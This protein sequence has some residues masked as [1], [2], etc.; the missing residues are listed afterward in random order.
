M[1]RWVAGFQGGSTRPLLWA[2]CGCSPR[3]VARSSVP[4]TLWQPVRFDAH[5]FEA[6]SCEGLDGRAWDEGGAARG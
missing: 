5:A 1:K 2:L 3:E 4:S 6:D